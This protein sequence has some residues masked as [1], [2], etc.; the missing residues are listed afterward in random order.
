MKAIELVNTKAI[1]D[2][3]LTNVSE[4]RESIKA[5][6]GGMA[7]LEG[8]L[9]AIV[10]GLMGDGYQTLTAKLKDTNAT[11]QT[12]NFMRHNEAWKNAKNIL[13]DDY[14]SLGKTT[15][16]VDMLFARFVEYE[17]A[18][19]ISSGL[20]TVPDGKV[21]DGNFLVDE[22][23]VRNKEPKKPREKK[24]ESAGEV[25]QKPARS[26]KDIVEDIYKAIDKG[27]KDIHENSR[28]VLMPLE[29]VKELS[30]YLLKVESAMTGKTE[31]ETP[32]KIKT[33]FADA[34]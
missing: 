18:Q 24:S 1:N 15:Q 8:G 27:L 20:L 28:N 25:M 29:T 2:I 6:L 34:K 21:L 16:A 12:R 23:K 22:E 31:K 7:A 33:Y 26:H 10:R 32:N 4:R 11:G 14:T 17:H 3:N 19:L 13:K 30:A 5:L 9:F